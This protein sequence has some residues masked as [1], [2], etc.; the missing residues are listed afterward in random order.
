LLAVAAFN[1]NTRKAVEFLAGDDLEIPH[2][3]LWSWANKVHVDRYE[4]IRAER[5]PRVQRAAAERH[6]E[7]MDQNMNL[8]AKLLEDLDGRRDEFAPTRPSS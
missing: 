7:L 1:G 5:L 4:E 3:T 2:Q 8:E 6:M